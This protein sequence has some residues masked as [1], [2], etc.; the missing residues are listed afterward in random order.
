MI[1]SLPN[2]FLSRTSLLR[3]LGSGKLYQS[4]RTAGDSVAGQAWFSPRARDRSAIA[5]RKPKLLA[6]GSASNAWLAT[7]FAMAVTSC[8]GGGGADGDA[9]NSIAQPPPNS[10]PVAEAGSNQSVDERSSAALNGSDSR[11]SDGSISS[12]SWE[13]VSGQLVSLENAD[14]SEASFET[15]EVSPDN[16]D[17]VFELTVRDN[18]GATATDTVTVTIV[19]VNLAPVAEAGDDREEPERTEISLDASASSDPDVGIVSYKWEQTA[20]TPVEIRNSDEAIAFVTMPEVGPANG[21]VIFQVTVTDTEDVT[22]TDQVE[23]VV[24]NVNIPPIAD[25][26]IDQRVYEGQMVQLDGAASTDQDGEVMAFAWTLVSGVEID[27][28]DLDAAQVSF[29]AP[30]TDTEFENIYE[31]SVTDDL[32]DSAIDSVSVVIRPIIPPVADAGV[33]LTVE[34]EALVELSAANSSD[35]D[36]DIIAYQWLQMDGPAVAIDDPAAAD[37]AFTAPLVSDFTSLRFEL[38]VTDDSNTSATDVVNVTVTPPQFDVSGTVTITDGT[39]VDGDVNDPASPYVENNTPASAQYLPQPATVGGYSNRTFTGANGRSFASGDV[40]DFYRVVMDQGQSALLRIGESSS[41]DLDLYLWDLSGTS[42]VDA[43]LSTTSSETVTAPAQ[44]E[45]LLEVYAFSGASNYV[46][47]TDDGA[48]GAADD[49]NFALHADFVP[50]EAIVRYRQ[51]APASGITSLHPALTAALGASE[52][53]GRPDRGMLVSLSSDLGRMS[54]AAKLEPGALDKRSA[55]MAS[56][57]LR[58]KWETLLAIKMLGGDPAVEYAEPNYIRRISFDPNDE[59][60]ERQWHYSLINLP[61]AWDISLGDPLVTV[62]VVDTGVLLGH[63]DLQG[64]LGDGFDFISSTSISNDGDGIDPDPDDPGDACGSGSSSFHGTHVAGTVGASTNNVEGVAGVAGGVTLMPLRALGCGGGTT[65][66]VIQAVRF[67]AGLPNDS[68]IIVEKPADIINLSLGGGGYSQ[69]AQ[70]SYLDARAAGVMV[71]AAAGNDATSQAHYPSAY[72]GVIS[73][74]SV[75]PD[76]V[77]ASYSNFGATI[78]VAA[79][80]GSPTSDVDQDGFPDRVYSTDGEESETG[81][82]EFNYEYKMGT[83][84]A[85]PHFAGVLALMKS[86]NSELTPADIDAM[87]IRGE[88]ST[89]IGDLGWDR[90]YGW[91]LVDARQAMDSAIA[92]IGD[93][94]ADKPAMVVRPTVLH[95]GAFTNATAFEIVNAAG[96]DLVVGSITIDPQGSWLDIQP[97][98]ADSNGI[99]GYAVSTDRTGLEAGSYSAEITI[100][101]NANAAYMRANMIVPPVLD[102]SPSAGQ[103]Y[104]VLVDQDGNSAHSAA[105]VADGTGHSFTVSGVFEGEYEIVAGSDA[106]NDFLICDGA[107]ACGKYPDFANPSLL[108]IEEDTVGIDF[109]VSFDW[110]FLTEPLTDSSDE[111]AVIGLQRRA[112]QSPFGRSDSMYHD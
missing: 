75:G 94:P 85:A 3:T 81:E 80:G 87:L 93:V 90:S 100:E 58:A 91:G 53:A 62:A 96:G 8:G 19:N 109:P 40:Y 99:G 9:A 76:R 71:V 34:S 110:L 64:T 73:V 45:Y 78:D 89:D 102:F 43:S 77:L 41:G 61:S 38:T 25:A 57:E 107:E 16:E 105:V 12:Y 27:I 22:D 104:I 49:A 69:F 111:K 95:F 14:T 101:S 50:N 66:D 74:S 54:S 82:I 55:A 35:S 39:L 65:Y 68:E 36:G 70:D 10:P 42:I 33:D 86:V 6:G 29:V 84:M 44:G 103:L 11:D 47:T 92:A 4:R 31:L 23:V 48:V 28:S 24:Y 97:G 17:L 88:I 21:S 112:E 26:G 51:A 67:A 79:P 46:L 20:G 37:I 1:Y 52:I 83:S 13:Q 59:L 32:G 2:A 98:D 5:M 108:L 56:A 63:P 15:P 18:D 72:A 60:Y 7:V 106:D 30:A